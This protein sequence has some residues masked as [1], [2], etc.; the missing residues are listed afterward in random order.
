MFHGYVSLPEGIYQDPHPDPS[1]AT[2]GALTV[3]EISSNEVRVV[4]EVESD[5]DIRL[6]S[7][8]K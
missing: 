4:G 6:V 7:S 8:Y 5:E 3:S 2:A 1:K